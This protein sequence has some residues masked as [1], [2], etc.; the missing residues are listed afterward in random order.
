[1]AFLAALHII[2]EFAAGHKNAERQHRHFNKVERCCKAE[3]K[4]DVVEGCR[5]GY[6]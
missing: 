6:N 2:Q 5:I 4:T 1:M 3:S